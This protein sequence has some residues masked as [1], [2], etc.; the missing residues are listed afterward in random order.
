MSSIRSRLVC[1]SSSDSPFDLSPRRHWA[2]AVLKTDGTA[3]AFGN[4]LWAFGDVGEAQGRL[5]NLRQILCPRYAC[6]ALRE[7]GSVAAPLEKSNQGVVGRCSMCQKLH[8]CWYIRKYRYMCF[9]DG[10][11]VHLVDSSASNYKCLASSN[12]CLTSSN[13]DASRNNKL[14][15]TQGIAT[16]NK[17]LL[18]AP[19]LTSRNKKLLIRKFFGRSSTQVTWGQKAFGGSGGPGVQNVSELFGTPYSFVALLR[20]PKARI[21]LGRPSC[22]RLGSQSLWWRSQLSRATAASA[23]QCQDHPQ[24]L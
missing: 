3:F 6:A 24:P 21:F 7:D 1:M 11:L 12:K 14:L 20:D 17:K 13:K 18:G 10:V 9:F 15:V 23:A 2:G 16:R 8:P 22:D 19:G 5:Q 4:A